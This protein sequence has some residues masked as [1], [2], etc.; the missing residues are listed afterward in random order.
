[1]I[2]LSCARADSVRDLI[3]QDDL[4]L[5]LDAPVGATMGGDTP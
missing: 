1:V 3:S 4:V 2:V 5:R